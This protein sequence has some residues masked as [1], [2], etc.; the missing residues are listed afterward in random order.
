VTIQPLPWAGLGGGG[1]GA[2]NSTGLHGDH[3][4]IAS[5]QP[6]T[7]HIRGLMR[8]PGLR[9]IRQRGHQAGGMEQPAPTQP[10]QPRPGGAGHT[11]ASTHAA[12]NPAGPWGKTQGETALQSSPQP[13]RQQPRPRNRQLV[14]CQVLACGLDMWLGAHPRLGPPPAGRRETI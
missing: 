9:L 4:P 3:A 1:E 12:T 2:A 5:A 14:L 6:T 11:L 8:L 10:Q 7:R 13:P